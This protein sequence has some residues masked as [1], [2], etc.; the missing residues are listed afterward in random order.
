[1]TT[2][3][4]RA[5][6]RAACRRHGL[7]LHCEASRSYARSARK[8]ASGRAP[9]YGPCGEVA[10]PTGRS[11]EPPRVALPASARTLPP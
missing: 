8:S 6:H 7:E 1:M 5:T 11:E 3:T 9:P 10:V 2:G 4:A